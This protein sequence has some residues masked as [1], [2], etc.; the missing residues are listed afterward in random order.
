[1]LG[2]NWTEPGEGA[3]LEDLAIRLRAQFKAD[4]DRID[5]RILT[6]WHRLH[7]KT[8]EPIS[9]PLELTGA[10]MTDQDLVRFMSAAFAEGCIVRREGVAI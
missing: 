10:R 4:S 7:G 8:P 9:T 2:T 1:M 3:T 5:A 6:I